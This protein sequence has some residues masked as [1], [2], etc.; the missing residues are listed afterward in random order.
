MGRSSSSPKPWQ[1][2]RQEA[3]SSSRKERRPRE[4]ADDG[5]DFVA[6]GQPMTDC[7]FNRAALHP[8]YPIKCRTSTQRTQAPESVDTRRAPTLDPLENG[9]R[10]YRS[11]PKGVASCSNSPR[12]RR[13]PKVV[14]LHATPIGSR[15]SLR[16]LRGGLSGV[17][18]VAHSVASGK[19]A[20][21]HQPKSVRTPRGIGV[22]VASRLEDRIRPLLI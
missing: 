18:N 9:I 2:P 8:A 11:F 6:R 3:E 5:A 7:D 17:A 1:A 16:V 13:I 4:G 22:I 12:R 21:P 20:R 10:N 14:C 15:P 19:C